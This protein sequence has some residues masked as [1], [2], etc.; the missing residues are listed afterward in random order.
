MIE[1]SVPRDH[2]LSSLGKPLDAKRRSSGQIL[3]SYPHTHDRYL[4]SIFQ[5]ELESKL[6]KTEKDAKNL[7]EKLNKDILL[8][9]SQLENEKV[10]NLN[11][12]W[13]NGNKSRLLFWSAKMFKK[14]PWQTVCTQMRLLL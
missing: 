6:E 8:L 14:P 1:K 4:Y 12:L 3:L 7:E 10:R 11:P 13:A 2:H 9:Q 5:K